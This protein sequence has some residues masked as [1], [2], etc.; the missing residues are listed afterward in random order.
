MGRVKLTDEYD[1]EELLAEATK[2]VSEEN[3]APLEEQEI[4]LFLIKYNI[5]TGE[6]RVRKK[7]LYE[8]YKNVSKAP[9]SVYT[10]GVRVSQILTSDKNHYFV[11]KDG[12]SIKIET[13]KALNKRRLDK[14]K[15]PFY[16]KQFESF[17]ENFQLTSGNVWVKSEDLFLLYDKWT[18]QNKKKAVGRWQFIQ[19]C[20]LF[21]KKKR[22]T[23][24]RMSWFGLNQ[25]I[26]NHIKD[27]RDKEKQQENQGSVP[28]AKAE[29]ESKD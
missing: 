1:L 19:L 16:R 23:Q 21:L 28:S 15:N 14:R 18:Y 17:M 25:N 27:Y 11:N 20:T 13:L 5:R 3:K 29:S 10:F 24:N 8:L 7:L 2:D 12:L 22:I 4:M 6:T 9:V 26:K